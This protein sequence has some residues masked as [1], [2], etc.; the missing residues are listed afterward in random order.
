M[1]HA[2]HST[3][4]LLVDDRPYGEAGRIL[5]VLTA[6]HGILTFLAQGVREQKSKLRGLLSLGTLAT[7][8]FV[9]GREVKRLTTILPIRRFRKIFEKVESRNVFS[10]VV[11]FVERV[12]LGEQENNELY[13]RF[14]DGLD[15]L[16]NHISNEINYFQYIEIAI[17]IN[18]LHALGYWR[19]DEYVGYTEQVF[20]LIKSHKDNLI[21]EI[22]KAIESTHL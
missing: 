20:D 21:K 7:F 6:E 13:A 1:S 2:I 22:N 19:G 3:Q 16:E 9:E 18:I 15:V 8:E 4:G 14:L 17:I 5:Y 11:N 10:R 12:V